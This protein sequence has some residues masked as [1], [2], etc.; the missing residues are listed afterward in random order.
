MNPP[1]FKEKP[2]TTLLSASTVK[3]KIRPTAI[4]VYSGNT[5]S[6]GS[7]IARRCKSSEKS[8]PI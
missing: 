3:T 1:R 6:T 7:S 8:K 5:D 2:Y 4:S